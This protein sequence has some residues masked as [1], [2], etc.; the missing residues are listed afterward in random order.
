MTTCATMSLL[1]T[2]RPQTNVERTCTFSSA[3]KTA[4]IVFWD[5]EDVSR[6]V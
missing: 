6:R 5:R 3:P 4:A 1:P 2:R